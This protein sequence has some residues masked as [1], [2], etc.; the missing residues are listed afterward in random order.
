MSI[1]MRAG[2]SRVALAASF[3]VGAVVFMGATAEAQEVERARQLYLEAD[4]PAALEAFNAVLESA[5]VDR[6]GALEAHRYLAAL[7]VVFEDSENARRHAEAAVALDPEV[8]APE[9]APPELAELLDGVRSE[10]GDTAATIEIEA[11]EPGLERDRDGRVSARLAPAPQALAAR[12]VL[13]CTGDVEDDEEN[14]GPLPQVEVTLRPSATARGVQCEA[15]AE[16]EAGALMVEAEQELEVHRGHGR[17]RVWP[18]V[19]GFGGGAVLA[20][21]IVAVAVV[22]SRPDDAFIDRPRVEGW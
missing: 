9:G 18:W 20:G 6:E 1:M 21:V 5:E 11:E 4:F 2:R 16:T 8:T 12:I 22:A 19:V 3:L 14:E 15:R 7:F 17:R 13:R 10:Q